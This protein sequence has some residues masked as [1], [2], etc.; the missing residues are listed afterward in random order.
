MA[1]AFHGAMNSRRQLG[2]AQRLHTVVQPGSS[3]LV[4]VTCLGLRSALQGRLVI[5]APR[6]TRDAK[7]P[8]RKDARQ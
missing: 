1:A 2:R 6:A 5:D 4:E 7:T 8:R 3:A